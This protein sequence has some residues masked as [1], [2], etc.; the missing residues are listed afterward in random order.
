MYGRKA[1]N[2]NKG[3]NRILTFSVCLLLQTILPVSVALSAEQEGYSVTGRLRNEIHSADGTN[4]VI[5]RNFTL[6]VQGPSWVIESADAG[7]GDYRL[8]AYIDGL[9]L[10]VSKVNGD[11]RPGLNDYYEVIEDDE[12]PASDTSCHS[13]LWLALASGDYL[14]S[15]KSD[16]YKPVW[17]LND[18]SLRRED[19]TMS[20]V[21]ER[22]D[23][24]LPKSL[25]YLNKGI[26]YALTPMGRAV[27][28]AP[29]TFQGAV[30]NALYRAVESTNPAGLTLPVSFEFLRNG[31]DPRDFSTRLI[32]RATGSVTKVENPRR[33]VAE[34][35]NV[36]GIVFVNDLRFAKTLPGLPALTYRTTNEIFISSKDPIVLEQK[37]IA[38][39]AWR[40]NGGKAR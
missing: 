35:L 18:P 39:R 8:S 17:M 27:I 34:I 12:V 6:T 10:T 14:K 5:N 16:Q 2:V 29:S 3:M 31:I 30:T 37:K 15:V 19:F 36:Q 22:L 28:R 13:I 24:G 40:A 7:R 38:F 20:G 25:T 32:N 26:V 1:A 9:L 11:K 21:L 23:G 4:R 33:S